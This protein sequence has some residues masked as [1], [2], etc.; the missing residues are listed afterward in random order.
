MVTYFIKSAA[1]MMVLYGFYYFFLR[2]Y[3][4]LIFNRFYLISSLVFSLI[5]PLITI[6]VKSNF[7]LTNSLD[8]I[9][10]AT[11]NVVQSKHFIAD[12]APAYLYQYVFI[13]L[14]IIV[15][16]VLLLRFTINIF[17]IIRKILRC[18]KVENGN[19]TLILVEEKTLPYSFFRY[20]FVNKSDFENGSILNELLL[21]EEGHCLQYHSIDIM[22]LEL[23]NVFLWF[24]PA[25]WLFRKAITLNHE[26]CAD[27]KVIANNESYNYNMLLVNLAIQNNTNYLVSNFKYS[28]I[29]YRIIMMTKN[30]PSNNAILRKI[31]AITL[32]LCLGVAF[33]FSQEIA[34]K[35]KM[36]NSQNMENILHHRWT[37]MG[38]LDLNT[39]DNSLFSITIGKTN[40]SGAFENKIYT[41]DL[42]LLVKKS[43]YRLHF[44][45][46]T[47]KDFIL[48]LHY[49][50]EDLTK[51]L[52]T[53]DKKIDLKSDE[54][55]LQ[56]S[57]EFKTSENLSNAHVVIGLGYAPIKTSVIVT[58]IYLE[59]V[60]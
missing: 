18:K 42:G 59:K 33:T 26:Y 23:I 44:L 25:L 46:K 11:G 52:C 49:G 51:S 45:V 24:N 48:G 38:Y 41:D 3:K 39:F 10:F 31:A 30:K 15:S 21:H 2:Y 28:L 14:F 40:Q 17:K 9:T 54:D 20:I 29:K 27:N 35:D 58:S 34:K 53:V 22:L 36:V 1:S 56:Q 12:A 57:F 32:F 13:I 37:N 5:I 6:P 47:S 7:T 43:T 8:K 19:T 16:S 55:F 60:K 4:I 50:E